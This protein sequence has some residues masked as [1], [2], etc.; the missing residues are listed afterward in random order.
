MERN[1]FI[2]VAPPDDL[3][4]L[5]SD[6]KYA[7]ILTSTLKF[8][9]SNQFMIASIVFSAVYDEKSEE[10]CPRNCVRSSRARSPNQPAQSLAGESRTMANVGYVANWGLFVQG[11]SGE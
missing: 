7:P 10:N 11:A 9:P 4:N 3:R 1:E 2:P 5:S 6:N 8:I